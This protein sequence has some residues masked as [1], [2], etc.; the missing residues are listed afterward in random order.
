MIAPYYDKAGI[1]IYCCDWRDVLP[2]LPARSID[3]TLTDPPYEERAHTK[4]RRI[5]RTGATT[6]VLESGDAFQYEPLSFPAISEAER[7]MVAQDIARLTRRWVLAFCQ[8][9]GADPWRQSFEA[10]RL[11]YI[12]TCIWH[13]PDGMPQYSG[14]RPSNGTYEAFVLMHPYGRKRWSGGGRGGHFTHNKNSGGKHFH[15]TQKPLPLI[16]ELVSLFS[17]PGDLV[18]DCYGG[19]GTTA[20]ACK[21]LGRR[22]ILIERNPAQCAIAVER[23]E[24]GDESVKRPGQTV[25]AFETEVAA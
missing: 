6:Q 2:V 23:L 18:L 24:T 4:G 3:F 9:E 14:D 17:E 16:L 19:S 20:V 15:E 8:V 11:E 1:T 13:K 25:M 12:R 22:C 10:A 21:I 7:F 5:K